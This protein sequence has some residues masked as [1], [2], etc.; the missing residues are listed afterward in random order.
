LGAGLRLPFVLSFALC[1]A[2]GRGLSK[3][4]LLERYRHPPEFLTR[5]R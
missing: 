3:W 5:R 4:S 2:A 1:V